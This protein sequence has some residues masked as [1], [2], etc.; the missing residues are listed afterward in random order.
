MLN[1]SYVYSTSCSVRVDRSCV[2][3]DVCLWCV[4]GSVCGLLIPW[5]AHKDARVYDVDTQWRRF[6]E[7]MQ[8]KN[9]PEDWYINII[10]MYIY[11]NWRLISR[12]FYMSL[13]CL[14][15]SGHAAPGKKDYVPVSICGRA[16]EGSYRS[17]GWAIHFPPLGM[18]HL[19][20][21][22]PDKQYSHATCKT[23]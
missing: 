14:G 2:G 13:D 23:R 15:C 7:I 9:T 19:G 20:R 1:V 6:F 4:C 11:N 16:L 10:Y 17:L 8:I 3:L 21:A 18:G 12:M 5:D 22:T